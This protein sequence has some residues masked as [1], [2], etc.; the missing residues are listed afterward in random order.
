MEGRQFHRAQYTLL[1]ALRHAKAARFSELM[2]PTGMTSD[3]FKFHVRK[4]LH[5]ALIFKD[6][7]GRYQL[8]AK[9][10]EVANNLDSRTRAVQKQPKISLVI[11]VSRQGVNGQP[12]YLFQHRRR[13]PYFGYWG[14]LSGPAAWGTAFEE[15]A[16]HEL[17]KQTGLTANMYVAGFRR[18]RDYGTQS[19]VL[20][21]KLFIIVH[22]KSPQGELKSQWTGGVNAWLTLAEL[23]AQP[24]Y[25]AVTHDIISSLNNGMPYV[26]EATV[27][28]LD[29]Y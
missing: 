23:Q 12:E 10:K 29:E 18:Q 6:E 19:T 9:G 25:F 13:N 15:T 24:R 8:T 27:Y 22:G 21:D 4:M 16:L 1:Q 3:V 5:A 17:Q 7:Q 20:E 2:R 26:D 11:V 28:R 14:L